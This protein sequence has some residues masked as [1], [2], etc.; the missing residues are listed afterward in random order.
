MT[1]SANLMNHPP[2]CLA[3]RR[4]ALRRPIRLHRSAARHRAVAR[5]AA[6]RDAPGAGGH[7]QVRGGT[8]LRPLLPPLHRHRR[9]APRIADSI[10]RSDGDIW[11]GGFDGRT[12]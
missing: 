9:R 12:R 10:R 1:T 6:A 4:D 5:H 2:H 11:F 3:P 8:S 7:D